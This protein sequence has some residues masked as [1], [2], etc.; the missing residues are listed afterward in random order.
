ML[1]LMF[2]DIAATGLF[3]SMPNICIP[4]LSH[5][6][7]AN[8]L[9]SHIQPIF[10]KTIVD[11]QADPKLRQNK[12]RLNLLRMSLFILREKS[13]EDCQNCRTQEDDVGEV[14]DEERDVLGG[15][16]AVD[17]V[18]GGLEDH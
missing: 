1:F 5:F 7:K 4:F 3:T 17:E 10:V 9:K 12:L 6:A 16:E 18:V 8:Y 14:G 2:E 11:C 13:F 15:A